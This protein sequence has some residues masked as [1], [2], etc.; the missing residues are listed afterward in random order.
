MEKGSR[1]IDLVDLTYIRKSRG[2]M[3]AW[4]CGCVHQLPTFLFHN[5]TSSNISAFFLANRELCHLF[6]ASLYSPLFYRSSLQ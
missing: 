3:A 2:C 6:A 4:L 5:L 1:R